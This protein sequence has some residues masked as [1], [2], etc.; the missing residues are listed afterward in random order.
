M[1]KP[2]SD[3]HAQ[4]IIAARQFCVIYRLL[5][6]EC[7]S[8]DRPMRECHVVQNAK[9]LPG[10]DVSLRHL[11]PRDAPARKKMPHETRA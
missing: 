2:P 6:L 4:D 8:A 1:F 3:E 5:L 7:A 10:D 11:L 9:F